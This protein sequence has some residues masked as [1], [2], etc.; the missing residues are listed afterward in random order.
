MVVITATMRAKEG[1][2]DELIG[3]MKDLV[4]KVKQNEPGALEYSFHQSKRDPNL[5]MV[6]EKYKDGEA[7]QA[8][9]S[10]S[11]FQEAGKKLSEV[12]EGGLGLEAYEVVA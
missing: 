6:Y 5:F 11:H 12:V 10:S 1:K 2:E 9:M 3:L 8:H 4:E 7:M